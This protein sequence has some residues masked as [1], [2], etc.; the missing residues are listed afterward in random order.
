MIRRATSLALCLLVAALACE[1]DAVAS[2]QTRLRID[3]VIAEPAW[4]PG[5]T[6]LRVYATA[7]TLSGAFVPVV[8]EPGDGGFVLKIGA[9]KKKLPYLTG[10][11]GGTDQPLSI[12]LVVLVGHDYADDFPEIQRELGKLLDA[13]PGDAKVAL[14]SYSDTVHAT[15]RLS[16][17]AAKRKLDRLFPDTAPVENELIK[18]V[19]RAVRIVDRVKVKPPHTGARK[20]VIVVSDGKDLDFDPARFKKVGIDAERRDVRIHSLAF[21]PEDNRR[22]LLGLGEMSKRSLGTFRWV[23]Q[24]GLFAGQVKPLADEIAEQYVL[25]YFVP[26]DEVEKKRISL[27]AGDV[28][29]NRV[30][31]KVRCGEESCGG[32]QYCAEGVC[33]TRA[34]AGGASI[35][36]W[37]LAILGGLLGLLLL[38]AG[39]G[40]LIS[41]SRPKPMPMPAPPGEAP[42]PGESSHRIVAVDGQGNPISPAP[43]AAPQPN[44]IQ[45]AG[46]SRQ[47][48]A[49]PSPARGAVLYVVK[50]P[51]AGQSLPVT[52]GF[53]IGSQPGLHLSLLGDTYA[54][55]VH[56]QILMDTAGNCTIVDKGSTNGTFV[57]GV[58]ATSM[59]LTHGMSITIGAA[60]LRFLIQ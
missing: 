53:T 34:A 37:V 11:F 1:R 56:A 33:V 45:P 43:A 35:L 58:R 38:L 19:S 15:P 21:S 26:T 6:R 41:R 9:S 12:G 17:A 32:D 47:M 10:M 5:M 50:G 59:R 22:P 13:L 51:G 28:E 57:N 52:H 7:V 14:V 20:M 24:S 16:P 55:S 42:Q 29:S 30:K 31:V 44:R 23:R 3:R 25:T 4:L 54:S 49:Q 46:P 36:A 40:F 8:G 60:E 39:I 27:L 18:A 48:A 2:T